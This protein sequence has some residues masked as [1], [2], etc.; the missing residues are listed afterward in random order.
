ML[1]RPARL[2]AVLMLMSLYSAAATGQS[3]PG[4]QARLQP[5]VENA[6]TQGVRLSVGV[7]D[8][9]SDNNVLLVDVVGY[10]NMAALADQLALPTL[11]FGRKMFEAA[12]PP[13]RDNV[14]NA[15]EALALLGHIYHGSF[16]SPAARDQILAWMSAQTVTS[17]IAAGVP[18]DVPLA[19]KTGE[20]GPVSHD[21]GYLLS[22]GNELALVIFAETSTTSDFDAAQL[23]LNPLVAQIAGVIYNETRQQ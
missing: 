15:S 1:H 16:L 12:Q 3:Y 8:L 20:N 7:M 19:H 6:A 2:F 5:L 17:K 18:A 9:T 13:E 23:Q 14:I 21:I 22:P 4:L 10:Q 11:Q